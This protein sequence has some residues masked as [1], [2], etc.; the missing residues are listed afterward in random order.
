VVD[1]GSQS[2]KNKAARVKKRAKRDQ[3][4]FESMEKIIKF[5]PWHALEFDKE[6]RRQAQIF[7]DKIE[8]E[9]QVENRLTTVMGAL[10]NTPELYA[11]Q[12]KHKELERWK[13]DLSEGAYIVFF[14]ISVY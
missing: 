5:L 3:N 8:L 9:A 10:F 6:T 11:P 1:I 13:L 4:E 7:Q 2:Q 12:G 14:H